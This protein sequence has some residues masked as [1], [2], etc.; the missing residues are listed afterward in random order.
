MRRATGRPGSRRPRSRPR[1]GSRRSSRRPHTARAATPGA[2]LPIQP[3][4]LRRPG[5]AP[6]A[7]CPTITVRPAAEATATAALPG[8]PAK[9]GSGVHARPSAEVNATARAGG[10]AAP[11]ASSPDGVAPTPNRSSSAR[12][13]H[14]SQKYP[15]GCDAQP[16]TSAG[17]AIAASSQPTPDDGDAVAATDEAAASRPAGGG[18]RHGRRAGRPAR[19]RRRSAAR[20]GRA[21]RRGGLASGR[22]LC[23]GSCPNRRRLSRD[24]NP[25]P[26]GLRTARDRT[27]LGNDED[28]FMTPSLDN[29]IVMVLACGTPGRHVSRASA[30]GR[31]R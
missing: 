5:R 15:G 3:P 30:G 14:G 31:S 27:R 6:V 7:S 16:T 19:R 2:R 13:W 11:T 26:P 22:L 4:P 12:L 17:F 20:R 18:R 21:G 29:A 9:D 24:G 23:R 8:P 28:I 10:C 25:S 1:T